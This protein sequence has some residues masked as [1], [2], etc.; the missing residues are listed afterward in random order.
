[1][2]RLLRYGFPVRSLSTTAA[3]VEDFAKHHVQLSMLQRAI[4]ASGSAVISLSNPYRHDMIACM[5]E[6]TGGSA[7]DK[8]LRRMESDLEGKRL[9]AEKPRINSSTLDL[10]YLKSLPPDTL[11]KTYSEF[12]EVNGVT[13]DSRAPVKFIDD[14]DLAYVMQRYR[15]VHDIFHAVLQMPTTMLGEVTVKWVEALQTHLPMC[16]SGAIFGAIRLRPRQRKI[17]IDHCLPWAVDTGRRA[18]FLLG[19]YYEERWEQTLADFHNEM[20]ITPLVQNRTEKPKYL[21]QDQG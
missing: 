20:N 9:L 11:G 3:F 21:V 12:L 17:Y 4:L 7:L 1:M 8:C 14:V 19:T 13:P 5:G 15:E 10:D 16:I 6:T 18:K 2:R